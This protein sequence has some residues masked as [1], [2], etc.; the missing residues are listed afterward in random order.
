MYRRLHVGYA[1]VAKL[2]DITEDAPERLSLVRPADSPCVLNALSGDVTVSTYE[3]SRAGLLVHSEVVGPFPPSAIHGYTYMAVVVDDHS[4]WQ[5][6]LFM[7]SPDEVAS[8]VAK[9]SAAF[10]AKRAQLATSTPQK[11][12]A[13]NEGGLGPYLSHRFSYCMDP[14]ALAAAE[15]PPYVRP[16]CD[17]GEVQ[18]TTLLKRLQLEMQD[19][20]AP[21]PFWPFAA[22]HACHVMNCT[23]GPPGSDKTSYETLVG[24]KPRVMDILPF[25]CRVYTVSPDHAKTGFAEPRS[26]RGINLG[27][28]PAMVGG[29]ATWSP[30]TGKIVHTSEVYFDESLMPWRPPGERQLP[31]LLP[32]PS[33]PTVSRSPS[34]TT[35]CSLPALMS[36]TLL[37]MHDGKHTR[38]DGLRNHLERLGFASVIIVCP[39]SFRG[40]GGVLGLTRE[41]GSLMHAGT[42][43][44]V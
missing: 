20:G 39:L 32:D 10:N 27:H 33:G 42:P 15:S 18:V 25:G 6:V 38:P 36:K 37:L 16:L 17:V 13:L 44:M 31:P 11:P 21:P 22:R 12:G 40:L 30:A 2:H 41:L 19:S 8:R 3:P 35:G 29:Y 9:F 14:V 23:R 43:I 4:L 34:P 7:H 24:R 26:W 5:M 28:D 1:T